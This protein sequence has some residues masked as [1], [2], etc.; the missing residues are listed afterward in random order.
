MDSKAPAVEVAGEFH[1]KRF[2]GDDPAQHA[3]WDQGVREA[4]GRAVAAERERCARVA[5]G[6]R[7]LHDDAPTARFGR[8][9]AAAIRRGE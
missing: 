1:V 9:V 8:E 3:E 4:I 5:E 2:F 7:F 6:G